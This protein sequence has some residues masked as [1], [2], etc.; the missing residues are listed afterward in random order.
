MVMELQEELFMANDLAL[1]CRVIDALNLVKIG[2]REVKPFPI[3]VLVL[4]LPAERRFLSQRAAANAIDNPLQHAHILSKSWPEKLSIGVFAEPI[5]EKD[6]WCLAEGT[7]H[8][9][10]MAEVV[11]HVI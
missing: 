7:L 4:W 10:P 1:P 11:A 9:N 3:H 6:P 8:L 5:D 2:A